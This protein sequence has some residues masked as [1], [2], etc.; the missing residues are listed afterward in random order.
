MDT[1]PQGLLLV[2]THTND[3]V[4]CTAKV[5]NKWDNDSSALITKSELKG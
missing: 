4:F 5:K 2:S 1:T 3:V